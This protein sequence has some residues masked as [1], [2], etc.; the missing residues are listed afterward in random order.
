MFLCESLHV[1]PRFPLHL[2]LLVTAAVRLLEG[3]VFLEHD[4][5]VARVHSSRCDHTLEQLM[6]KNC[7]NNED[8]DEDD[9]EVMRGGDGVRMMM[10]MMMRM[11]TLRGFMAVDAI[12]RSNNCHGKQ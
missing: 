9:D 7:E 1:F 3:H 6:M 2:F 11:M 8:N 12:I 5:D 10:M 4:L